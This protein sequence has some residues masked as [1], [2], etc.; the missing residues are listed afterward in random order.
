MQARLESIVGRYL[1]APING[2][3]YRIYFEEAGNGIPLL[4]Q[5]TRPGPMA[6]SGA[7]CWRMRSF[8]PASA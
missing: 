2:D 3:E 7:S 8:N 6:G 4:L 5:H 1:N